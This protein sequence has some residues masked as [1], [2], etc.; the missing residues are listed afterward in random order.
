MP[1]A[2]DR[3]RTCTSGI[4]AH[5]ASDFTTTPRRQAR[6][7]SVETNTSDTHRVCVYVRV[8]VC[9]CVRARVCVCARACACAYLC[10]AGAPAGG[11][12]EKVWQTVSDAS[13]LFHPSNLSR[14]ARVSRHD[15]RFLLIC[16]LFSVTPLSRFSNLNFQPVRL[17]Q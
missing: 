1:I 17:Q 15:H 3:I 14:R 9:V 7:A 5:C 16:F 10:I 8:C 6:L 4:R 13:V 2:H 11:Y 12:H